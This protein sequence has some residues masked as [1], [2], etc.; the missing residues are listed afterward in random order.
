VSGLA[1]GPHSLMVC[2]FYASL[3]IWR[4]GC[5]STNLPVSSIEVMILG[6]KSFGMCSELLTA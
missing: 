6:R 3:G 4:P 2:V 5:G 1:V